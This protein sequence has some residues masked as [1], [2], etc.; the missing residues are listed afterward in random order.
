M[1]SFVRGTGIDMYL[2]EVI[3]EEELKKKKKKKLKF[4]SKY[5]LDIK[6]LGF[7]LAKSLSE[8]EWADLTC[9]SAYFHRAVRY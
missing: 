8:Y 2:E 9:R 3:Q 5:Q 7:H 4:H 1:V 6:Y